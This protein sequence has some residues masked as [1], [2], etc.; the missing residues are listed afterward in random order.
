MKSI[1]SKSIRMLGDNEVIYVSR[2]LINTEVAKI[3]SSNNING[4]NIKLI[5]LMSEAV[6]KEYE[7]K[8][9]IPYIKMS[10]GD[11]KKNFPNYEK[12]PRGIFFKY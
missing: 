11:V 12:F 5:E 7:T 3:V 1:K 6:E 9:I 10:V 2:C 8:R 4:S